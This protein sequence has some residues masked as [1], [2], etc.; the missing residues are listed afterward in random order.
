[1]VAMATLSH[2]VDEG[3]RI[4]VLHVDGSIDIQRRTKKRMTC[5][6]HPTEDKK[7]GDVAKLGAG[8]HG[9]NFV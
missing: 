4:A 3:S 7:N 2:A 1:M 8:F 5:D 6:R 9:A